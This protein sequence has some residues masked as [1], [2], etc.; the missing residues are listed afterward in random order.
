MDRTF[1]II[2]VVLNILVVLILFLYLATIFSSNT[3]AQNSDNKNESPNNMV[4]LSPFVL[5][6]SD[7]IYN[8]KASISKSNIIKENS[9]EVAILKILSDRAIH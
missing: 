7:V 5:S 1:K 8:T 6:N 3:S 2:K 4:K 9:L